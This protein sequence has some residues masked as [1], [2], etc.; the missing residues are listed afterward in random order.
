[1]IPTSAPEIVGYWLT[2]PEL[3]EELEAD[4]PFTFDACPF[5]RDP[6][7][8][9]LEVEWGSNTYCNPPFRGGVMRWAV[10]AIAEHERGCRV[11]LILPH[12]AIQWCTG[13]LLDA[14]ARTRLT[15]PVDWLNPAGE[16]VGRRGANVCAVFTL[17]RS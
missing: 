2:P 9:G 17:E 6:S 16:R 7:F 14:G 5:P 8:D 10:K 13:P 15:R 1:M 4:G 12:R 11:V 3:M